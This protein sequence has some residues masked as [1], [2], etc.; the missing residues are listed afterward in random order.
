MATSDSKK[1]LRYVFRDGKEGVVSLLDNT[2][3]HGY[4]TI[5]TNAKGIGKEENTHTIG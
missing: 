2:I 3:N 5:P 1:A 4:V